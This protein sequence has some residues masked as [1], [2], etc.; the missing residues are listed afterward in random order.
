MKIRK[1]FVSNSSSSSFIIFK[2]SNEDT[3]INI[4]NMLMDEFDDEEYVNNI[5]S[6]YNDKFLDMLSKGYNEIQLID[7]EYG[8][9]EVLSQLFN[10]NEYISLG[11]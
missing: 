2:K 1:G 4:K 3:D 9:D 5:I 7:I 11:D 8:C 6:E 10:K